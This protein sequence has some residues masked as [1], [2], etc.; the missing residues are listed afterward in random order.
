MAK[1]FFSSKP[2]QIA[3]SVL[4]IT[5][6]IFGTKNKIEIIFLGNNEINDFLLSFFKKKTHQFNIE[7]K[8][9]SEKDLDFSGFFFKDILIVA[10]TVEKIA[11]N[12]SV[13]VNFLKKRKQK[14]LLLI[15]TSVPRIIDEDVRII[16]NC[17]LYDLNDLEQFFSENNNYFFKNFNLD[18]EFNDLMEEYLPFFLKRLELDY[19]KKYYL[20]NKIKKFFYNDSTTQTEKNTIISLLKF[21]LK[22]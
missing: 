14:P 11:F 22:D 17:F 16:D 8:D 1:D 7:S 12:K 10:S 5:E 9:L 2:E 18:E 15:D 13:I 21:L 4:K 19:D 6:T 20:E 3:K